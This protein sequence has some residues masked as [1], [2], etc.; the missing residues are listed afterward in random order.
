M[1]D[2]TIVG[3][4]IKEL[5]KQRGLTQGEL[6][7]MLFVSPQ[8]VSNWERGIS[9]P[10]L[11]NLISIADAFGIS[12]DRLLRPQSEDCFLGVDGGG[13]KTEFVLVSNSGHVYRRLVK[14][15]C[16]PNDIGY[17][18]MLSRL[19]EG[20]DEILGEFPKLKA[21]FCGISGISACNHAKRLREDLIKKHPQIVVQVRNDAFNLFALDE[22]AEMAVISGTGSVVF[23]KN[24]EEQ[25]RLGGWGYLFE[26]VGSAYDIGKAAVCEA[27]RE[28][29]CME[30]R[31]L[32]TQTL[33]EKLGTA[34]VWEHI[35]VLYGEGKSYIAKLASVVFAAYRSNDK[36]AVE[37]I[38]QKSKGLAELLNTGVR[39]YNPRRVAVASG[40]LFEHYSDILVPCIE[41]YTDVRLKVYTMPPVYGAC[42][43]SVK[44]AET[45]VSDAFEEN[46]K[47]SYGGK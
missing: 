12:V 34:T 1:L 23:V 46:F 38:E 28:E 42:R 35:N 14:E 5:R 25:R 17:T 40:G 37:I 27:L 16:N 3:M 24:G 22:S 18:K 43:Q 41:N 6:A 7:Q 33:L 11:E 10:E 19:E 4:E 20:I 36:K 9:P 45:T 29:D 15:G 26:D 13:T 31:C 8:A 44:L 21:I 30:P 39:L 2:F 47:I 32:M